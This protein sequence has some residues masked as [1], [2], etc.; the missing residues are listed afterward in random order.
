MA[1]A[2]VTKEGGG[3]STFEGL[4]LSM[5]R[6]TCIERLGGGTTMHH[7]RRGKRNK[8]SNADSTV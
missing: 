6:R 3:G 8:G 4:T 5:P 1:A 2:A 7:V